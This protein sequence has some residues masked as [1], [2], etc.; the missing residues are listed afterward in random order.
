MNPV[1]PIPYA[2]P[3]TTE[4]TK[5]LDHAAQQFETVLLNQLFS[6]LEHTF[7]ALGEEKTTA[8]SEQYRF[9]GI[10]ALCSSI[11]EHGGLGIAGMIVR[12]MQ[13]RETQS[14]SIKKPL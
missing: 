14:T 6:S 12:N 1:S 8:G 7:S 9:L 3:A 11:A 2:A 4:R 13:N 5:K 10:Q